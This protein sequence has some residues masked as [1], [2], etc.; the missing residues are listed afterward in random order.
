MPPSSYDMQAIEV[1][2]MVHTPQSL[3]VYITCV[4][5]RGGKRDSRKDSIFST[6]PTVFLLE[7]GT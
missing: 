3:N 4:L 5:R 7:C 2:H 6:L 1:T